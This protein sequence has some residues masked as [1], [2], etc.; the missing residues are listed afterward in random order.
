MT[1]IKRTSYVSTS[2]CDAMVAAL[3]TLPTAAGKEYRSADDKSKLSV[4]NS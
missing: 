4:I 3:P 2:K 1:V